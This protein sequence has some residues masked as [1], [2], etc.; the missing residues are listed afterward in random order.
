MARSFPKPHHHKASGQARVKVQGRH[1]YLGPWG[2][3]EADREYQKLKARFAAGGGYAPDR[4]AAIT[5]AEL[6]AAFMLHAAEH[7]RHADGTPTSEIADFRRSVRELLK[8]HAST[9]VEAFGP[10]ALKEVRQAMIDA[11]LARVLINQR[12]GRVKRI[13]RWGVE[14]EL[15][16]GGVFEALRAVK[17]LQ[18]GRTRARETDPVKPVERGRLEAVLPFVTLPVRAMIELQSLTGMRPGEVLCMRTRDIDRGGEVWVYTPSRHKTSWRGKRREVHLGPRAQDVVRRWLSADPDAYLFSPRAVR[19]RAGSG[20]RYTACSYGRAIARACAAAGV[21]SWHPNQLRH[22]V[23]TE[24]RRDY[25]LEAAQVVLGHSKADVTQVYAETN[26]KL[27][28]DVARK[29]G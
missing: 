24:V 20:L 15:A 28:S 18:V 9:V 14:N 27:A 3:A 29:I 10:L 25:G 1:Y 26:A 22:L 23:A 17:G 13:F 16:T 11:G 6:V 21:D 2:S 5:V 7:Y 4:G 19:P 8:M 12:V